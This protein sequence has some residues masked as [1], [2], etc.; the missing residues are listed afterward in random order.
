KEMA[1]I[2]LD[3]ELKTKGKAAV[4]VIGG[5]AGKAGG[6]GVQQ[7]LFILLATGETIAIAPFSFFVFIVICFGWILSDKILGKKVD[8]AM[9]RKKVEQQ[10]ERPMQADPVGVKPKAQPA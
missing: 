1:Y 3:E 2:P 8:T 10:Q 4:D 9:A 7:L 6:A 5:R